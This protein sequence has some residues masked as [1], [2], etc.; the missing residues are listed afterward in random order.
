LTVVDGTF[1]SPYN[2]IPIKLGVDISIHSATKYLGGHADL[3]AGV[4]TTSTKEQWKAIWQHLKLFGGVLSPFDAFLLGRGVKTLSLRMQSHNQNA[5]T[6]AEFLEKHPKVERVYYPGLKSHKQH[7]MAKKQMKGFSGMIAFEIK[8]GVEAGRTLIE[9][10][11]VINLAVSLGGV[12]SLIEHAAT[13]THTMVPREKRIE[14]G[15]TDG[16]IRF[17]VG[18]ENAV[19]LMDDLAQALDKIKIN[20]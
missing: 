12:E 1:A 17:S 4:A 15:I 7:D 18:C 9:S 8:G 14:A 10:V 5:L 20:E 2:Q 6:I 11:R 13:M 16:L 19:D 3:L